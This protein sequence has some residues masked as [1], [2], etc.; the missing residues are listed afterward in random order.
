MKIVLQVVT[1]LG[2]LF[3]GGKKV[4]KCFAIGAIF[5]VRIRI[6]PPNLPV[7]FGLWAGLGRLSLMCGCDWNM[8]RDRV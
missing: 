8:G 4:L 5:R 7:C 1:V 6:E 2:F 3:L